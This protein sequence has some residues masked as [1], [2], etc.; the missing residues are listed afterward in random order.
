MLVELA[1]HKNT[2]LRCIKCCC[3]K[4]VW[5]KQIKQYTFFMALAQFGQNKWFQKFRLDIWKGIEAEVRARRYKL[6]K[7][8][9]DRI[10]RGIGGVNVLEEFMHE[11]L[12][13][14]GDNGLM[15]SAD[16]TEYLAIERESTDSEVDEERAR[17][18]AMRKKLAEKS[19]FAAAMEVEEEKRDEEESKKQ[20]REKAHEQGAMGYFL[21]HPKGEGA[22][23]SRDEVV[24]FLWHTFEVEEKDALEYWENHMEE[25]RDVVGMILSGYRPRTPISLRTTALAV[26]CRH[27][28]ISHTIFPCNPPTLSLTYLG[29]VSRTVSLL[30]ISPLILCFVREMR[31]SRCAEDSAEDLRRR[32]C[33]E[34]SQKCEYK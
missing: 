17:K 21:A 27:P 26:P 22:F 15:L 11:V 29:L 1:R 5:H 10:F 13:D 4:R 24:E 3:P 32:Y 18:E 30:Q 28:S 20:K 8:F 7:K 23:H 25:P 14:V 16:H 9:I 2:I 6:E 12:E 34:K 33:H 31:R 19:A